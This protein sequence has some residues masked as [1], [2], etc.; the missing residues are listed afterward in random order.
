MNMIPASEMLTKTSASLANSGSYRRLCSFCRLA[1]VDRIA[2]QRQRK[3]VVSLPRRLRRL[4]TLRQRLVWRKVDPPARHVKKYRKTRKS[5]SYWRDGVS[6]IEYKT[7]CD[8]A[9]D[10]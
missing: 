8:S 7:C 10:H 9:L 2:G 6:T 1:R 5:K 3:G 4:P